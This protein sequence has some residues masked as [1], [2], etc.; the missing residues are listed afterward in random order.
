MYRHFLVPAG[1]TDAA[2]E[3]VG[4]ALEFARSIGARVTFFGACGLPGH[5]HGAAWSTSRAAEWLAKAEAA[6]R[7]HG[8]PCGCVSIDAA[9]TADRTLQAL[10]SMARTQ[11]CDLLCVPADAHWL[12]RRPDASDALASCGMPVLMC[13]AQRHRTADR[14]IGKLLDGH[15]ATGAELHA[16]MSHTRAA[17]RGASPDADTMRAATNALRNVLALRERPGRDDCMFSMLRER[18]STLDA[19]LAELE[20]QYQQE[21]RLLVALID[22]ASAVAASQLSAARF[23]EQLQACAQFIWECMGREEGVVLPAARRYLSDADWRDIDA[24]L[25]IAVTP[26]NLEHTSREQDSSRA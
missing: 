25:G 3:A 1:G 8:V 20:R 21:I 10:V 23:D 6:A 2:I 15:R 17:S 16:L 12:V 5:A 9:P 19:E 26:T 13:M 18:T 24:A 4:H 22:S 7:A 14:V 11:G